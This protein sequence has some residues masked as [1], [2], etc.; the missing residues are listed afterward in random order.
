[1]K[2]YI[3]R[4]NAAFGGKSVEEIVENLKKDGS[5]WSKQQLAILAK[6]SPTSL[7]VTFE[8][9]NRGG[10]LSLSDCLRMEYRMSQNFMRQNDFF[11]GVR[12]RK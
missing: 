6:N 11:E 4:I 8:Q 9:I 2:P 1:M 5:E 3:G 12:A 10:H 7:K